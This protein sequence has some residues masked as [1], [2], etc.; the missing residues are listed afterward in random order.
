M[1]P[2]NKE[3]SRISGFCV[4]QIFENARGLLCR[5]AESDFQ[6]KRF[7]NETMTGITVM[8][9]SI[10]RFSLAAFVLLIYTASACA[11]KNEGSKPVV[12]NPEPPPTSSIIVSSTEDYL[13]GLNDVLSVKV[14]DAPEIDGLYRINSKGSF[15]LPA[16]GSIDARDKTVEQITDVITKRLKGGYLANPIVSIKVN[17][18]NRRAFF[19]QGAVRRPGTYQIEGRVSL[20]KLI[21]IA[22][23]LTDEYSSTAFVMREKKPLEKTENGALIK[24]AAFTAND[25]ANADYELIKI[26]VSQLLK[27]DL[28]K[29]I[30]IESGDIVNIPISELFFVAGEVNKPGSFSFKE[31]TTLQ[32]AISL[33]G[34]LTEKSG[35]TAFLM[36]EK[37]QTDSDKKSVAVDEKPAD[38]DADNFEL[39]EIDVNKLM[40]GEI[41]KNIIIKPRDFLTVTE[42]GVFFVA[43]EVKAPGAFPLTEGATVQRAIS[44]AKGTNYEGNLKKAIIYRQTPTG[45]RTEI[46]VDVAAIMKGETKDVELSTND[47]LIVPNSKSKVVT[48]SIFDVLLRSTPGMLLRGL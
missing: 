18:S 36:R 48:K 27:G 26:N 34:G 20:L 25:S 19:I 29:N 2:R 7:I 39:V 10:A 3:V 14:E 1:S 11:Q 5:Q 32:Q 23:G 15:T 16:A 42:A 40:R 47:I 24:N 37:T 41:N 22:G 21:T 43:G 28:E 38:S 33:A 8:K 4:Q 35:A 17:Q 6:P 46:P 9:K 31:G 13:I 12:G 30:T 45:E 44:L